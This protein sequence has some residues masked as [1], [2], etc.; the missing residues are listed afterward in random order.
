MK[1]Y[2]VKSYLPG[3]IFLCLSSIGFSQGNHTLY[4]MRAVPQVVSQNPAFS[5]YSRYHFSIPGLSSISA[6]LTNNTVELNDIL[7]LG[8]G[9]TTESGPSDDDYNDFFLNFYRGLKEEN[10]FANIEM[11]IELLRF[12]F[13][14]GWNYFG[15]SATERFE[16]FSVFPRAAF[17]LLH[18]NFNLQQR[19]IQISDYSLSLMHYR[20]YAFTYNRKI[21]DNLTVGAN[22]KYLYGMDNMDFRNVSFD[23]IPISASSDL[24]LVGSADVSAS[25]GAGLIGAVR[26]RDDLNPSLYGYGLNNHGYAIDLGLSYRLLGRFNFSGSVLNLGSIT[27]KDGSSSFNDQ[28]DMQVGIFS[29]TTGGITGEETDFWQAVIDSVTNQ[30]E[31]GISSDPYTTRLSPTVNAGLGIRLTDRIELNSVSQTTFQNV[32]LTRFLIGANIRVKNTAS[33][34]INYSASSVTYESIGLGFSLNIGGVQFYLISDDVVSMYSLS[35]NLNA[36]FGLNFTIN[37]DFED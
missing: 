14:V 12:G 8:Q 25:N 3:L 23:W 30:I 34:L 29:T 20:E 32:V 16:I 4:N 21:L 37:N 9:L 6:G 10:N 11:N 7:S 15:F 19:E 24:R 1:Y 5:P 33:V 13:K 36:R 26:G 31:S 2:S 35:N 27:W 18:P 22:F 17:D 28:V